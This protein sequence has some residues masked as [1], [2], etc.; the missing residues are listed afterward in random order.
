MRIHQ[1]VAFAQLL[2]KAQVT[3]GAILVSSIVYQYLLLFIIEYAKM[4]E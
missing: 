4:T 2:K 3:L 1:H